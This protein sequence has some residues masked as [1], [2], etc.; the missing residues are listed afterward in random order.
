MMLVATVCFIVVM[1]L[2]FLML[3]G[4]VTTPE[5]SVQ[6]SP[7]LAFIAVLILGIVVFLLG[8]G[9]IVIERL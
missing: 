5:K 6:A 3:M 2:W 1:L 8:S 9:V 4:A 7:W